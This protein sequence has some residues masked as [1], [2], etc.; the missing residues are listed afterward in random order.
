LQAAKTVDGKAARD[1]ADVKTVDNEVD[2]LAT[3]LPAAKVADDKA[4]AGKAKFWTT[5]LLLTRRR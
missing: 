1:L 2:A 3:S 5:K 4:G